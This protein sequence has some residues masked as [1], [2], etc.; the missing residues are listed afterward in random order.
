[1]KELRRL[2]L[3]EQGSTAIEYALVSALVSL[4]ILA[5]LLILNVA[6]P[7]VFGRVANSVN[8]YAP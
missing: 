6:L 4:A 8:N 1:M 2:L 7:G 5:G 3:D